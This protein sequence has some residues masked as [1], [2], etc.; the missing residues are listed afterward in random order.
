MNFK[1]GAYN[2]DYCFLKLISIKFVKIREI[3]G[4]HLLIE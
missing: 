3:R 4:K 1:N 2:Y